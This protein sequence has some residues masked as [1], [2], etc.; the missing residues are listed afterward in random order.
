MLH[1]LS[2]KAS[3]RVGSQNVLVHSVFHKLWSAPMLEAV[4]IRDVLTHT[5]QNEYNWYQEM[6]FEISR[7]K[8]SFRI[9]VARENT[10]ATQIN[11]AEDRIDTTIYTSLSD[12]SITDQIAQ[13]EISLMAKLP[14]GDGLSETKPEFKIVTKNFQAAGLSWDEAW[15]ERVALIEYDLTKCD[16]S[17]RY[18]FSFTVQNKYE[19]CF[20]YEVATTPSFIDVIEIDYT[21][22]L[23]HIG[24]VSL[25][26][27]TSSRVNDVIMNKSRGRFRLNTNGQLL[28]P[29]QGVIMIWRGHPAAAAIDVSKGAENSRGGSEAR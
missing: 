4:H 19:D 28:W 24:S 29:G 10:I 22:I 9:V 27:L 21:G 3:K 26:Q 11:L 2:A 1:L 18:D 15:A 6:F 16:P 25:V 14:S 17:S 20:F 5:N 7:K 23:D 12:L 13:C 8:D